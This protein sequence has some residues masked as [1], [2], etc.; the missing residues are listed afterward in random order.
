MK[1]PSLC[2][3]GVVL[4]WSGASI[5]ACTDGPQAIDQN[6]T[7]SDEQDLTTPPGTTP[8]SADRCFDTATWV[9]SS[10]P[11]PTCACDPYNPCMAT[12]VSEQC[13]SYSPVG[14]PMTTSYWTSVICPDLSLGSQLVTITTQTYSAFC[15]IGY[16]C[17]GATLPC[18]STGTKYIKKRKVTYGPKICPSEPD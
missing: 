10:P 1:K 12:L 13:S 6:E 5:T 18:T 14:P 17:N 16:F 2:L 3:L 8:S 9:P 4:A 11:S 7:E 15:T